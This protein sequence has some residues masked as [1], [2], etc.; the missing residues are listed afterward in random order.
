M[1]LTLPRLFIFLAAF[2]LLPIHAAESNP[3][4]SVFEQDI[5]Q[6]S[7]LLTNPVAER[8][9]EGVRGLSYY[10]HWDAADQLIRLMDDASP[11]VRRESVLAL[12]RLGTANS[13]LPLIRCLR[14][15]SWEIRQNAWLGLCRMT[16]ENFPA[17]QPAQWETWWTADGPAL[18]EKKLLDALA[19]N[20]PQISRRDA[21]RALRHF[22]GTNSETTLLA[23]I[24]AGIQPPPTVEEQGFLAE[25]LERIGTS[26]AIPLL[27]RSPT[28]PAAWALG[29]IGGPEAEKALLAFP[30]TLVT[31]LNLDRLAS[32]NAG[33][34]IPFLIANMGLVTYRGQPDD[35]MNAERQPIQ[36]VAANLILRSGRAPLLQELV[37]Q[38][39]EDS[40]KPPVAHGPRPPAP[41]D[42]QRMLEQMRDE[43]KPGFVR[44]DGMTTSQPLV[45]LCEIAENQALVPRLLP[46]LHHPAFVPRI[47]VATLLGKLRATAAL[48][49]ILKFIRE[50]YPFSDATALASGK[51]FDH[52]QTVR[53]R[54]FLCLA[55]GRM[56]GEEARHALEQF[57]ADP[58]QPRDIRYCSV[59]GLGFIGS[60]QSLPAL[61]KIA[62]EDIIWMA[63]DE[64]RRAVAEILLTSQ[65]K[66]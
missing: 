14:D 10:K 27:A 34:L 39:L 18:K 65:E 30:K 59:V 8:R 22:A 12:C 58:G 11:D 47:Y 62:R 48:P 31:L 45:A 4:A 9:V 24:K 57:A 1:L 36:R 29:R 25:T 35:L 37:L 56:G 44:G 42:W 16:A 46:L 63:R 6:F 52:S 20:P 32:T 3:P 38:E 7:R 51:H 5:R 19:A 49:E 60:P 23:W 15:P 50:G 43:L 64:A 55:L 61:R 40:M 53:W 17:G 33:P 26:N 41:P 21:L 13:I 28:D 66:E 54:G 2:C